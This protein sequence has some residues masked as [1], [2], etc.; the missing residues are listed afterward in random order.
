MILLLP[1]NIKTPR[2]GLIAHIGENFGLTKP[3]IQPL[4]DGLIH[5]TYKASDTTNCFVLQR[6]NTLVFPKP[7]ALL[8]NYILMH[9][10][11]HK[12]KHFEIPEPIKTNNNTWLI[13]DSNKQVWRATRFVENSYSK[14]AVI[15][16]EEAYTTAYSFGHFTK[17]LS[18]MDVAAIEPVL[19]GFHNL[20]L[21]Y[22]QLHQAI[23]KGDPLRIEQSNSL[24]ND[25]EERKHLVKLYESLSNDALCP[26]RLM[27][28][29][30]KINNLLFDQL[31]EEVICPI[32]LDTVMP[33]NYFS[34]LGDMIRTIGC[35]ENEESVSWNS[36]DIN[37]AFY[38]SIIEGYCEGIENNLTQYEKEHLHASGLLMIYMQCIRFLADYLCGDV[39]YHTTHKEQNFNRATNQMVFLKK[40]E[41]FLTTE[42][43]Q[44]L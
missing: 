37:I 44:R 13:E 35:T 40:L 21:R 33:G 32:D 36:L 28:H 10:Y 14:N 30:C 25:I 8:K 29:D 34:D 2:D 24:I 19:P 6:I 15:N 38:W 23:A 4:G 18:V 11:L 20:S 41:N 43:L 3:V 42:G 9:D 39:Y 12:E 17:L 5:Q 22:K 26:Q 1:M 16:T 7:E 27:H 31:T